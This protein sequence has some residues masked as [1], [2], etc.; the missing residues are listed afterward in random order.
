MKRQNYA[1]FNSSSTSFFPKITPRCFLNF[2][3]RRKTNWVTFTRGQHGFQ[4]LWESPEQL[5]AF[6][7][8]PIISLVKILILH[9][10]GGKRKICN[11]IFPVF[12]LVLQMN[13]LKAKLHAWK[14]KQAYLS[15]PVDVTGKRMPQHR[16][17]NQLE[18]QG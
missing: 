12:E 3:R 1:N 10:S 11:L 5:S 15:D 7:I 9:Q 8:I 16:D 2:R 14:T 17:G 6:N 18:F 4:T 13:N